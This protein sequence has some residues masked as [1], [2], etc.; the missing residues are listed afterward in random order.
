MTTT[1]TNL[2]IDMDN[3]IIINMWD[4]PCM[5]LIAEVLPDGKI[6]YINKILRK[7][8]KEL[9]KGNGWASIKDY[10]FIYDKENKKFIKKNESI[11]KYEDGRPRNWQGLTEFT[12]DDIVNNSWDD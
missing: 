1:N 12:Y 11:V 6:N 4:R 5:H 9:K 7:R 8:Y 2:S 10:G 3:L